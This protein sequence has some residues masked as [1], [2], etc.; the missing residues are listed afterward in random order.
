VVEF[1]AGTGDFF[2]SVAW[3][4]VA[5]RA[6]YFFLVKLKG[7]QPSDRLV[8]GTHVTGVGYMAVRVGLGHVD[9]PTIHTIG[10]IDS[11]SNLRKRSRL[12][13]PAHLTTTFFRARSIKTVAAEYHGGRH[14]HTQRMLLVAGT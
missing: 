12:P 11:P 10:V 2:F 4:G 8:D 7:Q 14:T 1:T 13:G 3:G 5:W 6:R 9:V